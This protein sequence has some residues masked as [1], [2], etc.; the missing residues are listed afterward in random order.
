MK[1]TFTKEERA[2]GGTKAGGKNRLGTVEDIIAG[3]LNG[4]FIA[5]HRLLERLVKVGLKK[6]ECERCA[7]AP[8]T[9]TYRMT[10]LHHKNGKRLDYRFANLEVL[11][12]NCHSLTPNYKHCKRNIQTKAEDI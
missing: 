10:E 3:K 4:T 12:P 8:S 7:V 11:C 1:H 2:K 5:G 9:I 6:D